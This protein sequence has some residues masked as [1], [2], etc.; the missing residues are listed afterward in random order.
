[1]DAESR[2]A[3]P[4]DPHVDLLA[5]LKVAVAQLRLY[6]PESPQV[7]KAATA[8]YQAITSFLIDEGALSVSRTPRGLLINGRRPPPAGEAAAAREQSALQLLQ[9]AQVKTLTFRKGLAMDEMVA[10]LHALTRKF[11]DVREG[12]EINRRLR[13]AR[14]FQVAVDEVEYVAVGAGDLVIEDAAARLE[15]SDARVSEIVRTLDQIIEAASGEGVGEQVRLHVMKKLLDYDPTLILKAQA[16]GLPGAAP[17]DAPGWITFEQARRSLADLVRLLRGA[18]APERETLRAVGHAIVGGFRHD[19]VL[20]ALLKK[21]LEE[22]ALELLPSW[23]AQ[24]EKQAASKADAARRAAAILAMEEAD[25]VQ[26]LAAEAAP[27][28]RELSALKRQDV[29]EEIVTA[30]TGLVRHATVGHRASAAEA[31]GSVLPLLEGPE[32][33]KSRAQ[34]EARARSA[35]NLER[36]ARVYPRLTDLACAI[37]DHHLLSGCIEGALPL[38]ELLRKHYQERDASFPQRVELAFRALERVT[39]GK[40]FPAVLERLHA[41]DPAAWRVVETLD[42]AASGFI[43]SEMKRADAGT[44][45]TALAQIL[46]RAGP[47]AGTALA[48]EVKKVVV[49]DE[50]IRLVE[51]IPHAMVDPH[52]EVALGGILRHPLLAVRR[53]AAAI[54][55]ERGYGRAGTLLL[56]A[57]QDESD[58]AARLQLVEALGRLR[59]VPSRPSLEQIAESRTEPDEVRAAAC[60]ALGRIG[61]PEAIQAIARACT[62]GTRGLAK[63]LGSAGP[64]VRAAAARALEPFAGHPE[65]R[66]ALKQAA[67]DPDA[68]VRD[69]AREIL[70]A[71]ILRAFGDLARDAR[72]VSSVQEAEKEPRGVAGSLAEVPLLQ[73]LRLIEGMKRTGLLA[74]HYGGPEARV[75]FVEG[76]AAAADFEDWKD[77]EAVAALRRREGGCFLFRPGVPTPRQTLHESAARLLGKG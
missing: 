34:A 75:W 20:L 39:S 46:L 47:G 33:E 67:E 49:P 76:M 37:V 73:V 52:A 68:A 4:R 70:R 31:L 3:E 44:D 6:P 57:L 2:P 66:E 64:A 28:V 63:V 60:L 54:L 32:L 58:A 65:A 5:C 61:R 8:A 29:V 55:A 7:I 1:M 16:A 25:Q 72:L 30:L 14:V 45:R 56:D 38:L 12:K 26:A 50:A 40:G 74:L 69:A 11:W 43:L 9:E 62:R 21:F 36:E 59:H 48:D 19:P 23:L 24:G 71:P 35:L 15:A 51:A 77:A 53:R 41:K 10:F 18:G 42:A 13:E 27:L 22:E 17:G